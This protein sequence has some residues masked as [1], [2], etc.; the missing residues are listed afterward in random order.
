LFSDINPILSGDEKQ[1]KENVL[2][3]ETDIM[4]VLVWFALLDGISL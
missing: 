2:D 1:F 3:F 4:P